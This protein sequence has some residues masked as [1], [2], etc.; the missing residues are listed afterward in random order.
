MFDLEQAIANWR[1]Q[2]L[3][4]G[5]CKSALLDELESHLRD[6]VAAGINEGATEQDAFAAEYQERE[7]AL[8]GMA[9]KY[10]GLHSREITFISTK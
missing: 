3:A 10:A 2:M 5:I 1:R 7:F 6:G 8:L 9:I 4:A